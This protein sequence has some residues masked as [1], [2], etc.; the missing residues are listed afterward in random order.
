MI[1]VDASVAL[2]IVIGTATGQALASDVLSSEEIHAPHLLDIEVAHV[3][4][5]YVRRRELT[6]VRADAALATL[7]DLPVERHPHDFLLPRMWSLRANLTG[8]DAAYVALAEI[9]D[10]P[11]WTRDRR[12]AAA[13]GVRARVTLV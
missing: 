11:L 4:R 10:V 12:I 1:V 5:G 3:L 13:P 7:T 8:Y 2:E 6:E 9:L